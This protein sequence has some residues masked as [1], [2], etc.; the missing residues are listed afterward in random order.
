MTTTLIPAIGACTLGFALLGCAATQST[1]FR[2]MSAADHEQAAQAD[3][4]AIGAT[5]AEHREAAQRLRETEHFACAEVPDV[6]RDLGPF[7]RRDRIVAV[8]AVKDR[9]F[10]KAPLQLFG[11]DVAIR[12]TP[13][14]TEQ[15]IGRVI[16]C[17]LAHYAVVGA[18]A[19]QAPS[20]L[21]VRGANIH[22]SSTADGFRVSITSK[23]IDVAR[24]VLSAGRALLPSAS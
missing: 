6:E 1:S 2:R 4:D 22:V 18:T 24:Q 10:P 17:H 5:A 11:V 7:E 12:A 20:P 14:T 13:G 15:W 23:D 3:P 19:A 9:V 16:E 8:D 21:L